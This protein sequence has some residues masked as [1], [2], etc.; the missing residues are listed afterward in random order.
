M[1]TGVG[2]TD[3]R[4]NSVS[5]PHLFAYNS[6]WT[7]A[8]DPNASSL[9]PVNSPWG[10]PG[11]QPGAQPEAQPNDVVPQRDATAD[12]QDYSEAQNLSQYQMS[13]Y[14]TI[15]NGR[16]YNGSTAYGRGDLPTAKDPSYF[17][18]AVQG[19]QVAAA[20]KDADAYDAAVLQSAYTPKR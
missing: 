8:F 19:L 5:P 7:Q 9:P 13:Q 18:N 3:G 1:A 14:Q 11:A 10:L 20:V 17:R 2:I 6:S 12:Y 4:V 16:A 15:S